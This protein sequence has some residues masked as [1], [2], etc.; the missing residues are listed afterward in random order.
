MAGLAGVVI[1]V[2]AFFSYTNVTESPA[3]GVPLPDAVALF[4]TSL[5][6]P[7]TASANS[8]TLTSNSVRGGGT[9]SLFN[10]FTIDEGSAQ[11]EFV[12]GTVSGTSVTGVTRGL[13]PSDG[14][15]EV[16]AL[17]FSHRRGASVKITNFPLIQRLKSQNSGSATFENV[18]SYASGVVPSGVDQLA[19]V[20]YVLSA[21][22]GT[23]TLAFDKLIVT[24]EAGETVV[25]GNLLFFNAAEQEWRRASTSNAINVPLGIAQG[26]GTDN[27][28]ITGG[29]LI[30][31]R[32]TVNTGL[33]LGAD[34]YASTTAGAL[35]VTNNGILLGRAETASVLY[36]NPILDRT[37]FNNTFS[38]ANTF[39]GT[40]TFTGA[41][42]GAYSMEVVT[43]TSSGT[44]TKDPGLKYIVVETVAGGGG[45]GASNDTTNDTSG[46]GG[47]SGAY[48][49][50]LIL[51][52]AL[53][54]TE[55][56][57]VGVGGTGETNTNSLNNNGVAGGVSS[58]G[59][60]TSC[61]G[62]LAGS[63]LAAGG[64]GATP[65]LG[66]IKSSG[67]IGEE[68]SRNGGPNIGRG[69]GG[70]SVLGVIGMGG[71]G[72][73]SFGD[74]STGGTGLAGSIIVTEYY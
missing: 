17:K 69:I 42:V 45:G 38:G 50:R 15:T 60:L 68:G 9:L 53:A 51:A 2:S 56:V 10:C 11:A 24:G 8:F 62:G 64:G 22:T 74:F 30:M 47:G 29:I 12:C 33:T 32:N 44:W 65:T 26:P 58:F 61:A 28:L 23:S 1:A 43:F 72:D 67:A 63:G 34:Y 4:E 70:R 66:D 39:S 40:T 35:G 55:T 7:I 6:A 31:G 3:V 18:L 54:A 71:Q 25:A 5:A 14:T 59:S 21:I 27:N 20:G 36:F 52:S 73:T 48:S 46:G 37:V 19:D 13:S 16:N 49:K 57:T 41:V